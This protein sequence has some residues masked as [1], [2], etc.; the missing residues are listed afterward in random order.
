MKFL[1]AVLSIPALAVLYSA[2][3]HPGAVFSLVM[4]LGVLA[5]AWRGRRIA[6]GVDGFCNPGP[7][8]FRVFPFVALALVAIGGG[9]RPAAPLRAPAPVAALA[10]V[11]TLDCGARA[12]AI[13]E[14]GGAT[15]ITVLE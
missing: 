2:T 5:V 8:R 12:C 9:C 3:E 14:V 10:E 15:M 4:L 1:A 7:R 11:E 6:R 13:T